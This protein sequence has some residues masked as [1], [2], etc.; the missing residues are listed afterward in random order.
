MTRQEYLSKSLKRDFIKYVLLQKPRLS[1]KEITSKLTQTFDSDKIYQG[2]KNFI[3]EVTDRHLS[4]DRLKDENGA[5]V[6]TLPEWLNPELVSAIVEDYRRLI[7]KEFAPERYLPA[8]IRQIEKLT[9]VQGIDDM[10]K[11]LRSFLAFVRSTAAQYANIVIHGHDKQELQARYEA[12]RHISLRERVTG[13]NDNDIIMFRSAIAD[14]VR[15]LCELEMYRHLSGLYRTVAESPELNRIINTFDSS[16][17]L[18]ESELTDLGTLSGNVAWDEEYQQLVPVGFFKRNIEDIDEVKA[19]HMCFFL[20]LSKH[21][22]YLIEHGLLSADGELCVFTS[23]HTKTGTLPAP[24]F[25][26]LVD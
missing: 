2:M 11:N 15:D 25:N 9:W 10:A 3:S 1:D 13:D 23:P 17:A 12:A 5:Y 16:A 20:L 19:F 7:E 6:T 4:L 22:H 8:V 24:D 18:A 26:R 21:E 14:H